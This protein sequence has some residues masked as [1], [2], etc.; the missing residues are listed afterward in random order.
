MKKLVIALC[1]IGFT[2]VVGCRA[3]QPTPPPRPVGQPPAQNERT[4]TIKEETTT[5]KVGEYY[6]V[7]N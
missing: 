6:E 3:P 5:Q 7:G 1:I 4:E 2:A